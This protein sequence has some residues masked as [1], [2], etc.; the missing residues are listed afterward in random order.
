MDQLKVVKLVL[1]RTWT[2][3][4]RVAHQ[5]LIFCAKNRLAECGP[6]F[7]LRWNLNWGLPP[8]P[9]LPVTPHFGTDL[10][11]YAD[12]WVINYCKLW[13]RSYSVLSRQFY[14]WKDEPF[15]SKPSVYHMLLKEMMAVYLT[16]HVPTKSLSNNFDQAT[17]CWSVCTTKA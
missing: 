15:F 9:A 14:C 3:D 12:C 6:K 2:Q 16:Q 4:P 10:E 1:T 5:Y 7:G 8:L 11:T 13:Y 17:F